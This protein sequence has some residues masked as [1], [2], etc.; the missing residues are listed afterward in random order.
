LRP[1]IRAVPFGQGPPTLHLTER[2]REHLAAL[3]TVVRPA[4]GVL[5]CRSGAEAPFVYSVASGTLMSFRERRGGARRVLGFLFAGDVFGLSRRGVY[6]NHVKTVTPSVVFRFPTDG[7]IALLTRDASLQFRF[8]CKTTHVLR[9]MQRQSLMLT[10]N[11]PV[12][13]VASF[14]ALLADAQGDRQTNRDGIQL[15]MSRQDIADFLNLSPGS[16][17]ASLATLERQGIVRLG[18]D[19][20]VRIVDRQRFAAMVD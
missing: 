10:K 3:G 20:G 9:E 12:V 11:D 13:R 2:D 7:L 17:S 6:V 19:A 4:A 5:L 1:S 16:I 15:P 8:L 18:A 14:L